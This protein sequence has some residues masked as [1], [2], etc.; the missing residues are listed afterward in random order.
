MLSKEVREN[1]Q[2]L[3]DFIHESPSC[4][5][6]ID[7]FRSMLLEQGYKEL[8]PSKRWEI[9]AGGKYFVTQNGSSIFAIRVPKKL[10]G[11]FK[12]S[13]AHSDSPCFKIK[14]HAEIKSD[15]YVQINT[16][17]YG[18][19]IMS[20]WFDRPLSAAGRVF[21][22]NGDEISCRLLN[23]DRNTFVI[24][25]VAI[26][27]NREINDGYKFKANSDTIP[28]YSAGSEAPSLN[29]LIAET[30]GVAEEDIIGCD[31]FI[32]CRDKGCFIGNGEELILSPRLDDLACACGLMNGLLQ[33]GAD[34]SIDVCCVF[35]NEEVGSETKQG[36]RSNVLRDIL[37][38]ITYCLGMD[39]QDYQMMLSKS[40]LV[41]A[42]NAHAIH[43]NHP[44][45]YDAGNC[46]LM[47]GGIVIKFNA[48]Q[49]YTTD[50]LSNAR[51]KLVCEKAGVKTQ[52]MAN[53]SDLRGGGTLGSLLDSFLPISSVDIGLPQL[54][55]HSAFE[56]AGAADYT[57]LIN[58]MKVYYEK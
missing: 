47:N 18:G 44:E 53:R 54:A 6:V 21:V 9:K 39:E 11:G 10:K 8:D 52:V 12:I 13:A 42:D 24:P 28:L 45:L 22:K 43:P 30:L 2:K 20:S 58:A 23:I 56:T 38:R 48:S 5:H 41:S 3:L 4:F 7:N 37:R 26:H 27:Q 31:L 57:D 51:F 50:G 33:A 15:R 19:M 35:D 1:A 36:A 16:E 46:S 40:F 32:Y 49:R 25:S 29:A 55:M 34:D 14:E 17:G